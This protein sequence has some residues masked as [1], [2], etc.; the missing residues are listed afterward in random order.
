MVTF[1]TDSFGL[2]IKEKNM[3]LIGHSMG[4]VIIPELKI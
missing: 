1:S 2:G 3:S 4:T